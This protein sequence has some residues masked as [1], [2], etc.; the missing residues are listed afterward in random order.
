M[1]LRDPGGAIFGSTVEIADELRRM[2]PTGGVLVS[3]VVAVALSSLGVSY[4]ALN[5]HPGI[6]DSVSGYQLVMA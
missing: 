6:D 5:P 1:V 2:S 3:P 4:A